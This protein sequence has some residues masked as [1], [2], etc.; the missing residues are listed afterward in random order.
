MINVLISLAMTLV[1]AACASVMAES[2][3]S[4]N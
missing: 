2:S 1:L 4:A 3:H